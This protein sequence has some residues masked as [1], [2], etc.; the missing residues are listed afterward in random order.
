[1]PK[2]KTKKIVQKTPL[3]K[4]VQRQKQTVHIHMD[5]SKPTKRKKT[6]KKEVIQRQPTNYINSSAASN[7]SHK[8]GSLALSTQIPTIIQQTTMDP[9]LNY[10]LSAFLKNPILQSP[11]TDQELRNK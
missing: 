11:I 3:Q 8:R 1:M 9:E 6:I 7:L 10:K 5:K 2:G 4:Q